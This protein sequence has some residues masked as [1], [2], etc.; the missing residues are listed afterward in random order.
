[1]SGSCRVSGKTLV[2]RREDAHDARFRRTSPGQ[3]KELLVNRTPLPT[4]NPPAK[5]LSPHVPRDLS[6][7]IDGTWNQNDPGE[8]TNV[9]KLFEAT[10]EGLVGG[11][12]ALRL[13]VPGVG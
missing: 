5:N 6:V 3:G 13:Y 12:N 1:G 4:T 9:R 8:L 2:Q 10:S 11:R 7:F